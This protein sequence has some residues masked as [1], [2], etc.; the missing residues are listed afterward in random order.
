MVLPQ[1]D[2]TDFFFDP[3]WEAWP[4]LRSGCGGEKEGEWEEEREGELGLVKLKK[5]VLIFF[6]KKIP[7]V[8]LSVCFPKPAPLVRASL[9]EHGQHSLRHH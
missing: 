9:C 3:L 8:P 7:L 6:K 1:C 5:I 4:S 2:V